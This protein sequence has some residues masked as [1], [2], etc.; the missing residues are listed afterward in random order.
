RLAEGRHTVA[1][2]AARGRNLGIDLPI[3]NGVDQ[4]VNANAPLQQVVADLLARQAGR[5]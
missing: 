3:T 2:L 5:E 1:A 4:V